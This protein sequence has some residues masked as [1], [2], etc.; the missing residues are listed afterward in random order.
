MP[1]IRKSTCS[2]KSRFAIY[3]NFAR[4]FNLRFKITC[5][6]LSILCHS[7]CCSDICFTCS[8]DN[9]CDISKHLCFQSLSTRVSNFFNRFE[10][11]FGPES[12]QEQV[13]LR[14]VRPLLSRV[15]DGQNAS[16]FAYG[17]TGSGRLESRPCKCLLVVFICLL[18]TLLQLFHPWNFSLR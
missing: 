12:T 13:Y 7:L 10:H 11:V 9:P 15:M 1:M 16:V 8:N 3:L 5:S 2:E 6:L 17:P 14:C 18:P 4:F